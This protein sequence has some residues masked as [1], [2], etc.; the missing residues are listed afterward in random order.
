MWHS[1]CKQAS[2]PHMLK[3]CLEFI[4]LALRAMQMEWMIQVSLAFHVYKTTSTEKKF[5]LVMTTNT[6]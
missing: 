5:I 4:R 2:H 1:K 6:S 3:Y